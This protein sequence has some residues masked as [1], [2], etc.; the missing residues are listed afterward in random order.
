MSGSTSAVLLGIEPAGPIAREIDDLW[1]FMLVLSIPAFLVFLVPLLVALGRRRAVED[2]DQQASTDQR[3]ALSPLWLY[4]GGVALPALVVISV[5][6]ATL[7][8]MRSTGEEAPEGAL[9]V[10]VIGNQWWWEIR[11]PDAGVV[12]ANEIRIPTGRPVQL[13][14]RSADVIHS[15]WVPPLGGKMDLLPEQTNTMVIQADEPGRYQGQCA[16]FCGLQHANMRIEVIAEDPATFGAWL[17]GQAK[18]AAEPVG[19]AAQEGRAVFA[20]A[21]CGS[22]HTIRGTDAAGRSGPDLTHLA[23]RRRIAAGTLPLTRSGLT[24]WVTN[25]HDV[26]RGTSMPDPELNDDETAAVVAYLEG[27]R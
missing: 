9:A 15:F 2:G 22:C 7:L 19:P 1:R 24:E 17:R 6:G 27:L 3:R 4:G 5:L 18:P 14:L 25:P 16:E 23:S 20:A 8:T 10:D 21:A 13:R 12:T 26:K 11:Y